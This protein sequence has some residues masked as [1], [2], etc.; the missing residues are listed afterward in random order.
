MSTRITQTLA[1]AG[2]L[3]SF[4][5]LSA[6]SG[7]AATVIYDFSV[8]VNTARY[9]GFFSYDDAAVGSYI[10]S[11]PYYD[12]TDFS[13]NFRDKTYT[14]S[15]L[16]IDGRA[17][18]ASLPLQ[19]TGGEPVYLPGGGLGITPKGGAL[20]RFAFSTFNPSSVADF[21]TLVGSTNPS[22]SRFIYGTVSPTN[23]NRLDLGEGRVAFSVRSAAV[24]E[25]SQAAGIVTSTIALSWLL[26][27]HRKGR[28]LQSPSVSVCDRSRT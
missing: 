1:I 9:S 6:R 7:V 27:R 23:P 25:P 16:R 10:P 15:D 18:P 4:V 17:L 8:D 19:I 21:F 5:A 13:F 3:F 26:W 22:D 24:P 28:F 12:V 14:K 2:A 20:Q 11:L